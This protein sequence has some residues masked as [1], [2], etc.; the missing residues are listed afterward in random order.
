[1]DMAGNMWPLMPMEE[2]AAAAA[3][4]ANRVSRSRRSAA[5]RE[6]TYCAANWCF[7]SIRMWSMCVRN[8]VTQAGP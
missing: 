6:S 5:A 3:A 8:A 1:M 7:G 2:E 4:A